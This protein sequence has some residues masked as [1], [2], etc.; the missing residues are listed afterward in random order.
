M[1]KNPFLKFIAN[2]PKIKIKGVRNIE[3]FSYGKRGLIYTGI[4]GRKRV[5]IKIK[6]QESKASDTIKNEALKLKILNKHK[7][8][9]KLVKLSGSKMVYE[10]IDGD[11]IEDYAKRCAK[12]ELLQLLKQVFAQCYKMDKLKLNKEEMHHPIKHIIISKKKPVMIDF[13]R[14][15]ES[16]SPK[17]VTQ[18]CQYI[19]SSKMTY[20]L[21]EKGVKVDMKKMIKRAQE[22]K[23]KM[24]K[25][26]FN[27]II[28]FLK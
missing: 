18:F 5:A 19:I 3:L 1:N 27:K 12:K 22:Y 25:Q 7:I 13:E 16:E 10:F 21:A 9:P 8:G 28:A 11:F 4:Y 15:Y 24:S 23:R 6:R 2:A 17:N 14:C 20:I 26:N